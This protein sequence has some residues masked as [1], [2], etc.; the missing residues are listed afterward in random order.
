M[1]ELYIWLDM[2][3]NLLNKTTKNVHWR[4]EKHF[5]L[6]DNLILFNQYVLECEEYYP[7]ITLVAVPQ[8]YNGKPAK[9]K[10][11]PHMV[12]ESYWV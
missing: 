7:P 4:F 9:P 6:D 3:D 11:F 2:T 1:C 10:E 5:S 12:S 8:V